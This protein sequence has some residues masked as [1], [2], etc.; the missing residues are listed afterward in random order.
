MKT[1]IIAE[2][3]VNHNGSIRLAKN[4]IDEAKKAK[5]DY[6]KFQTFSADTLTT[7]KAKKANYQKKRSNK[8]QSQ[9][10]MLKNLELSYDDHLKLIA[11]SKKKRKFLSCHLHLI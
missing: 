10:E 7:K 6:I 4:M 3:G 11:H 2:V 1:L 9:Y 5:A 8:N